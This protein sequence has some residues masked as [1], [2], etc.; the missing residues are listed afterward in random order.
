V[1]QQVVDLPMELP[2]S[3]K[4][5]EREE[6]LRLL[7][8]YL[9][10]R[11]S[12]DDEEWQGWQI[13]LVA[14]GRNNLLYRSVGPLGD[15]AIKFTIRDGR[16]RAGREYRSL[17]ALQQAGLTVAPEPI[18]LD[19]TSYV[20]PVVVQTWLE[21]EV[22]STPP[23]TKAEWQS[24]LQ[25]LSTV[26]TVSPDR[27]SWQLP[28]AT[29]NAN[30]AQEGR[31][32]VRQQLARIPREAQPRSLQA[33]VRR[34]EAAQFPE[35]PMAPVTLCRLDNNISNYIRRPGQWASVDW[36]YSGWG[37]PAFDVAN[38][39]THVAYI[40]VPR[41]RWA[42]IIDA[43]CDLG[44]DATTSTRLQVY[45]RV[46]AMWWVARLARYLYEIPRGM[47]ERLATW[48]EDWQTD[49]E[50]KYER[51]LSLA[52]SMDSWQIPMAD[53]GCRPNS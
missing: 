12:H 32:I 53:L 39:I 15:L 46:M 1:V 2:E 35:W 47:D 42:W 51:Y 16:D 6:H 27:I 34:F 33:V 44:G 8:E 13:K 3:P 29:I 40:Q 38:T 49:M 25:H 28:W 17:S 19:R 10:G 52:G 7:L 22:K 21:G 20:Q 11:D 24:L 23:T 4:Y 18:L 26:H 41:S 50:E 43:Y 31:Q 9:A 37:D 45:C 14:G 30:N 36:E 48:P 5:R